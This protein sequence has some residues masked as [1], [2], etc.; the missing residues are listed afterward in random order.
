MLRPLAGRPVF[1]ILATPGAT[2]CSPPRP[3]CMGRGKR[4]AGGA[5]KGSLADRGIGCRRG[6][7]NSYAEGETASGECPG[8]PVSPACR[9]PPTT[10]GSIGGDTAGGVR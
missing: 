1:C 5:K 4:W 9:F 6:G 8:I 2:F 3:P 10:A 7:R